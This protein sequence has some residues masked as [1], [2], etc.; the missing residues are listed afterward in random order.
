MF[1][2]G[3]FFISYDYGMN[4]NGNMNNSGDI[5]LL[6]ITYYGVLHYL[7]P[8]KLLGKLPLWVCIT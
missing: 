5:Y 2:R 3:P 7:L 6:H 1:R 4:T 8:I